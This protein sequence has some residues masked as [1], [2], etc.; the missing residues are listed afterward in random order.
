VFETLFYAQSGTKQA[1][2]SMKKHQEGILN[3]P[4]VY[5]TDT[6]ERRPCKIERLCYNRYHHDVILTT[7]MGSNTHFLL[8][9][10][11]HG[12]RILNRDND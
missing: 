5:V 4:T 8:R 9:Q 1:S 11:V 7:I 2:K 6:A 12:E 10:T 3:S